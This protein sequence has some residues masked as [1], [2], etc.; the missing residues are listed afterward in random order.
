[1]LAA[2]FHIKKNDIVMVMKG[3]DKGKTGK[4][5]KIIPEKKRA[6]VEKM[7]IAKKHTRQV[8]G[9]KGTQEGGIIEK[10][11]SINISNLALVCSKC[12]KPT[13]TGK[14]VL[15]DGKKLRVCKRCEEMIE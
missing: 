9:D 13:R 4:V 11:N 7:N 3:K 6:I 15:S 1:M 14:T 5:L 8:R 2:K 12:N 10:E